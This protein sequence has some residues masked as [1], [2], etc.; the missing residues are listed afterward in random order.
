MKNTA[1]DHS[2]L[3]MRPYPASSGSHLFCRRETKV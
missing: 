3:K 1:T 2:Q